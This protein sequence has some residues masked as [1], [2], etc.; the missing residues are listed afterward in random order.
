[1]ALVLLLLVFGGLY[2][3][4]F[5]VFFALFKIEHFPRV[6]ELFNTIDNFYFLSLHSLKTGKHMKLLKAGCV[7]VCVCVCVCMC[8]KEVP[9]FLSV[10][11]KG[12]INQYSKS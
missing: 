10:V 12:S 6:T 2:V 11:V 3:C 8:A 1:M 7:C 4:L 9:C 5:L